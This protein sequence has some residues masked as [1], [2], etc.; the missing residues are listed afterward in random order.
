MLSHQEIE[1]YREN[2]YLMVENA[3]TDEQLAWL[4]EIT[5]RL[6]DQ[7]RTVTESDGHRRYLGIL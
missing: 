1:F 3:V 5:Y 2:G 4:R 6:I 7:S